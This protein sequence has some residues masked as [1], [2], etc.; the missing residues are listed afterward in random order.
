MSPL[1]LLREAVAT[2]AFST[3]VRIYAGKLRRRKNL[4]PISMVLHTPCEKIIVIRR[5]GRH[6]LHSF[7]IWALFKPWM[8]KGFRG[9][10]AFRRIVGKQSKARVNKHQVACIN[11]FTTTHSAEVVLS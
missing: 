10:D 2:W 1:L 5:E 3:T 11:R 4:H 9:G 7:R 6:H 8:P